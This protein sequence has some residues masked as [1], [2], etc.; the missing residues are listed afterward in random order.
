MKRTIAAL[1]CAFLAAGCLT[2]QAAPAQSQR[3]LIRAYKATLLL[4]PASQARFFGHDLNARGE[5]GGEIDRAD[6]T[7]TRAAVWRNGKVTSLPELEGTVSSSVLALNDRGDA[8]GLDTTSEQ[9]NGVFWHRGSVQSMGTPDSNGYFFPTR[10]NNRGQ[11]IGFTGL[12]YYIWDAGQFTALEP[13]PGARNAVAE[14]IN[15]AGHVA[16]WD[17][18]TEATARAVLWRDGTVETLGALPGMTDTEAK[19]LNDF[20]HVVGVSLNWRT[21]VERAFLW[22]QGEMKELPLL[23]AVDDESS[24]ALAVNM[25]GQVVGNEQPAN[26]GESVAVLWERNRAFDLNTLV[27]PTSYLDPHITLR[28]AILI[29][30]WGQILVYAQDDRA[31]NADF[32]YLLTPTVALGQ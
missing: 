2:A 20:D 9:S 5:I 15:L 12:N 17:V 23:N 21:G 3:P 27:R 29:N 30:E 22:Q 18:D 1:G 13:G 10:L 16:G 4:D 11:A 31:E 32:Y 14:D 28:S 26:S 7:G 19:G 8:V 24:V 6:L 25:W